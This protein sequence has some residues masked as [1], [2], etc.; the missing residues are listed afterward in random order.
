MTNLFGLI[1]FVL[2]IIALV[3]LVVERIRLS[4]ANKKALM[5]LIQSE[6]DKNLLLTKLSDLMFEKD[7]KAIEQTDGFLKFVSESRDAAF[8]YIETVQSA[9]KI[10]QKTVGKELNYFNTYGR[11]VDSPHIAILDKI[12]VAYEELQKVMPEEDKEKNENQ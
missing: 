6:L 12:L 1:V 4:N 7:N 9:L 2:F 3:Y 10:F 11:T 5:Q 8:Q